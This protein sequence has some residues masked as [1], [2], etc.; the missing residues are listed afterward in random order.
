VP[1]THFR[2]AEATKR[3]DGLILIALKNGEGDIEALLTCSDEGASAIIESTRAITR[4][5]EP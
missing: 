3:A 2:F 5:K 4:S 1:I